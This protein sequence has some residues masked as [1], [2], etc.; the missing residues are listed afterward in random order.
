MDGADLTDADLTDADP[1][2]AHYSTTTCDSF[3]LS[4]PRQTS[5]TTH[6]T[7]STHSTPLHILSNEVSTRLH[8]SPPR[9][10]RLPRPPR[11]ALHRKRNWS[12]VEWVSVSTERSHASVWSTPSAGRAPAPRY[13]PSEPGTLLANSKRRASSGAGVGMVSAGVGRPL[14][15]ID[16][17]YR[18]VLRHEN[19]YIAFCS[20]PCYNSVVVDAETATITN[21]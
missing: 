4:T 7:H 9:L 20:Q 11:H 1:P 21:P 10:P 5:P 2:D 19:A 12:G 13:L 17:D 15:A 6:S 14:L 18:A 16:G 8:T 3:R